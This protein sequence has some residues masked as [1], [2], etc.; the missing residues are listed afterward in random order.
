MK[1][2]TEQLE[3]IAMMLKI[4]FADKTVGDFFP[5][6]LGESIKNIK[7]G[8]MKIRVSE[9]WRDIDFCYDDRFVFW[10][11]LSEQSVR[12]RGHATRIPI[13]DIIKMLSF[14]DKI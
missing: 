9:V 12:I 2:T 4:Q 5:D 6:C 14:E 8:K 10:F 7:I 11:S 3:L 13:T 1:Y